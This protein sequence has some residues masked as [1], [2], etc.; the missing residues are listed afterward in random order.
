MDPTHPTHHLFYEFRSNESD[1]PNSVLFHSLG[2]WRISIGFHDVLCN[3][4]F[5]IATH[6][7]LENKGVRF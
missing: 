1:D 4:A 7:L 5:V 2:H 3:P 6:Q